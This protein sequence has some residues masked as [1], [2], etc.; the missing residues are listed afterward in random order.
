MRMDSRTVRFTSARANPVA[1]YHLIGK[2]V[3]MGMK[4][5]GW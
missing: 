1:S 4:V 2:D 5:G 3:P